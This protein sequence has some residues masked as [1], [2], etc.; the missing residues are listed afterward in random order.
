M[1]WMTTKNLVHFNPA[2]TFYRLPTKYLLGW[3]VKLCMHQPFLLWLLKFAQEYLASLQVVHRDLACRNILIGV[4]KYLKITDFGMSRAVLSDG[5]YVK[6][7]KARLPLK[8]MA[9]E[10]IIN[11]E[12]TS[13]SDV[14]S[15]GVSLWEISTLGKLDM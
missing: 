3:F 6:T 1:K 14:W 5:V 15:F 12:F 8:W 2:L 10:S 11:R 7:T 4:G 9:I 13:A